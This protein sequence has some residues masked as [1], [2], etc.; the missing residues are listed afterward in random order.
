[1]KKDI[2]LAEILLKFLDLKELGYS[3]AEIKEMLDLEEE[4]F[5]LYV[6]PMLTKQISNLS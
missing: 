1:M 5:L 4:E 2:C 3:I 6:K